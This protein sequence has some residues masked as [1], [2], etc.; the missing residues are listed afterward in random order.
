[1][2]LREHNIKIISEVADIL[3]GEHHPI[4]ELIRSLSLDPDLSQEAW[5]ALDALPDDQRK[6]FAA[7][8]AERIGPAPNQTLH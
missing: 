7:M 3:L 2:H 4:T 5:R 8:V 1:M 6:I